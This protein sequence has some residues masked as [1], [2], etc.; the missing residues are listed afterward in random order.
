[1]GLHFL[2]KEDAPVLYLAGFEQRLS[3]PL[4]SSECICNSLVTTENSF[5]INSIAQ[6][7][8]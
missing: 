5:Y 2:S 6:S 3:L 1:M 4:E 8:A 7:T